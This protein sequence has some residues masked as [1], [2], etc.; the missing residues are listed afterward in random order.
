M[1]HNLCLTSGLKD[2]D[3]PFF[4]KNIEVDPSTFWMGVLGQDGQMVEL[5]MKATIYLILEHCLRNAPAI[6]GSAL[7]GR[8]TDPI[9]R[10]QAYLQERAVIRCCVWVG[11][12]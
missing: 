1:L 3:T 2:F 11:T 9:D 4:V 8:R 10:I 12:W 7:Y 6:I 5:A